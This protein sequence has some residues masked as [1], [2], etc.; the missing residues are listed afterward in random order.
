MDITHSASRLLLASAPPAPYIEA[1]RS[2]V[3]VF[4]QRSCSPPVKSAYE[5]FLGPAQTYSLWGCISGGCAGFK[6]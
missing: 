3:L 1:C 5:P 6:I 4:V 2:I